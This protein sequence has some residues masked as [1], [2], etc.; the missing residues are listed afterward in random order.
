M[1]A[2]THTALPTDGNRPGQG[3]RPS[4]KKQKW[5][6]L[7]TGTAAS[8][9]VAG[10]LY[11]VF[12]PLPGTA[13]ER[14]PAVQQQR[15]AGKA[16]VSEAVAR[17]N[18]T[19]ITQD[20]VANECMMSYGKEVL[21]KMIKRKIIEQ[22][23]AKEG[24]TVAQ[25]EVDQEVLKIS[26]KFQMTVEQWYA[27]LRQERNITE[28]QYRHDIIWPML[29]LKK[30]AGTDVKVSMKDKKEAFERNYGER[31][32]VKIIVLDNIRRATECW[33][34]ANA[35]PEEFGRL[36]RD[37]SID[38][39]SR[40]LE[41]SVPPIRRFSGN[42]ASEPIEEAA[43]KLKRGEISPVVEANKQ[44]I[45]MLCE[46]RTEPVV[47]DF[48]AVQKQLT[49]DLTEE[50]IQQSVAAVFEKIESEAQIHNYLTNTMTDGKKPTA[51]AKSGQIKQVSAK[52]T[53]QSAPAATDDAADTPAVKPTTK[54][55][56]PVAQ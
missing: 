31:V 54:A 15:A 13:Q 33:E 37:Y 1:D 18:G 20:E 36:V 2:G 30:L 19:I 34:K 25:A 8:I 11:Q 41:G 56:K 38:S 47:T 52:G 27:M 44:F 53:K 32:K 35:H 28:A 12:R 45:I 29:A 39:G 46:G 49:E 10:I 16:T 26:Q 51:G 3:K 50:K 5:V 14:Q 43:F 55:R 17:V 48:A 22:A 40:P 21:D 23:C 7:A 9:L 42:K 6:L 4:G 24:L